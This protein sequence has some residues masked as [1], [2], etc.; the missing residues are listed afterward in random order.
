MEFHVTVAEQKL[1]V[2]VLEQYH[3][4]LLMEISHT[5]HHEFKLALRERARTVEALLE[6]FCAAQVGAK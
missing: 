4:E 3:R 5:D 2:E 1:L 6:R